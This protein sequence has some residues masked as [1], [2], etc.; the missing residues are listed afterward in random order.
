MRTCPS[1]PPMTTLCPSGENTTDSA[2]PRCALRVQ[3]ASPLAASSTA[4]SPAS[5]TAASADPSGD[6]RTGVRKIREIA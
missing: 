1:W 3:R 4:R 6:H 5:V 2:P